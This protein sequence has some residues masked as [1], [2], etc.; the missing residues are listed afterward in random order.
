MTKVNEIFGSM[1]FNKKVM[2]KLLPCEVYENLKKAIDENFPIDVKTGEF[3]AR[4]MKSWAIE[5]GATHFTHWFQPLT[6]ITAE[7]HNSFLE[8]DDNGNAKMS[9]SVKRVLHPVGL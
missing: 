6:E 3:V 9:F 8:F 2:K 5:K 4:A 7:K 1:V